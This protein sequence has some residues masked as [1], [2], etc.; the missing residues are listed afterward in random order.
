M[1]LIID[2]Y[3]SFTYNLV[4]LVGR[5]TDDIEVVRND[6][7]TVDEVRAMAPEGILISPGPGRPAE[8]GITE[9]LIEALGPTTPVLGVC[10][11]HQAIG[12]VYGGT[13][14]HA[15]S[16]MH[17]KTSTVHHDNRS[18]F[19]DVEQDFEA[20]RYHSLVVDRD[21]FPDHELEISAETD[22]GVI[23]GLRHRR[24]PIEGIQFH[25]ES[26]MTAAG[27][28]LIEN[29]LKTLAKGDFRISSSAPSSA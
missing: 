18:V 12:E 20:T 14:T 5:H 24:Y 22:D 2:N 7:L 15:P 16:L 17:G 9:P 1:I 11:G 29:W 25:P 28:R 10:L 4:H 13:I 6:A 26:V 19:E 23:M 3:D 8:A 27:P 21:D